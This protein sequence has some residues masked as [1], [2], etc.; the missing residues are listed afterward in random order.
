[1]NQG[2]LSGFF[3]PIAQSIFSQTGSLSGAFYPLNQNPS[4]YQNSG[5]FASHEDLDSAIVQ[6]GVTASNTFYPLTNPSGF[7]SSTY[8]SEN[9]LLKVQT[10]V[11]VSTDSTVQTITGAKT[12]LAT[13]FFNSDLYVG[14]N[15]VNSVSPDI[16]SNFIGQYAGYDATAPY[17]VIIGYNAGNAFGNIPNSSTNAIFIGQE[18]GAAVTSGYNSIFLGYQAGNQYNNTQNLYRCTP[19]NSICIGYRAGYND[20]IN[21]SGWQS[22]IIIGNYASSKGFSDS[23]AIGRGVGN[24]ATGQLNIGNILYASNI[25]A[26]NASASTPKSDGK[27]GILTG[28][29]K[30]TLEVNG[31]GNFSSGLYVKGNSVLTGVQAYQWSNSGNNIYYSGANVGINNT[32]PQY[33]LDVSGSGNFFSGLCV[34]GDII[35]NGN[36]VNSIAHPANS[37]LIGNK[38]GS[39]ATNASDSNFIGAYA[40]YS[41]VNAQYSNFF[42]Y[43]AGGLSTAAL[44]SNFFGYLAGYAA[45]GAYN[46][47]FLGLSAGYQA[48]GA[49]NNNFLGEFCGYH[50]TGVKYSTFIGYNAG[51][52]AANISYSH[53]FGWNAGNQ[54]TGASNAIF[55][56][57]LAGYL[58]VVNN[59]GNKSSILIGDYTSTNGFSNSIVI[60]K[61][62]ANSAASQLN[63]G[64]VLY[65]SN[66][67]ASAATTNVPVLNGRVGIATGSP[68]Y[69]LEVNGIGNFSSGLLVSGKSVLTGVNLTPYVTTGQTGAFYATTNP[70]GFINST[71]VVFDYG[72]QNIDGVKNFTGQIQTPNLYITSDAAHN[73]GVILFT[74]AQNDWVYNIKEVVGSGHLSFVD[75]NNNTALL[76]AQSYYGPGRVA[77]N[78]NY[79]SSYT[80]DVNGSGNF[81]SN[82]NIGGDFI[83]SGYLINSATHGANSN[84]IGYMAGVNSL[85]PANVNFFGSLA[86]SGARYASDSVFFGYQAGMSASG[87][88]DSYFFGNSAGYQSSGSTYSVFMGLNAGSRAVN[89]INSVFLGIGAGQTAVSANDC[90]YIGAGAGS[91]ANG[92]NNN[93]LGY[94]AGLSAGFNNPPVAYCNCF[95]KQ[96]GFLMLK[97]DN[98]NFIGQFA[99]YQS[100]GANSGNYLGIN[101]GYQATGAYQ[102]QFIGDSAGY[103]AT[104][105]FNSVMIGSLAGSYANNASGNSWIGG[106]AGYQAY[107]AYN[108]LFMGTQAG[109]GAYDTSFS[110]Y[111]GHGAGINAFTGTNAVFIGAYAGIGA[112]SCSN[113]NILGINAGNGSSGISNSN[114]LGPGA[115]MSCPVVESSNV[116]GNYAGYGSSSMSN[117]NYLGNSAGKDAP[118]CSYNNAFGY[119][120]GQVAISSQYNNIFGYLA[121]NNAKNTASCIFIGPNA[122]YYAS[123]ISQ[124][125]FIGSNAGQSATGAKNS[126]FIGNQAGYLDTKINNS[127]NDSSILIGNYTAT[128]GFSNSISIGQGTANSEIRQFN[129]GN[130]LY[131]TGISVGITPSSTP[132]AGGSVGIMTGAPKYTLDVNGS[133]RFGNTLYTNG[134]AKGIVRYTGAAT[135]FPTLSQSTVIMSGNVTAILPLANV[136]SGSIFTFKEIASAGF[137]YVSGSGG[138]LIDG[139]PSYTLGSQY[140]TVSMQSDGSA[141][142]ILTVF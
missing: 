107:R 117:C 12:F 19:S 98:S 25:Y 80:L 128:S 79:I 4:G 136:A 124:S 54:A 29:P 89:A 40:G 27:V 22:S 103:K 62:A 106:Q 83:V 63:I 87:A 74:E 96:A 75:E 93:F 77:I 73:P 126:I 127:T 101:A 109:F 122:G 123:G 131:G 111:I 69:T 133:G 71:D 105:A 46:S 37:N 36:L 116:L 33:A 32:N 138:N 125:T 5:S 112:T 1:M 130:V 52:S 82:L 78:Q 81:A 135:Y 14:G 7:T 31:S 41:G 85:S 84:V 99:G 72:N 95:G 30:Y 50:A 61:G 58:D 55:I 16:G 34:S 35:F 53:F 56:G 8:V 88:N 15:I 86:G 48:S 137:G 97:T 43:Y 13:G 6:Y 94:N 102:S 39:G 114:I 91:S 9:Y 70:S 21:N 134:I 28:S 18:A 3:V 24:S 115:A 38:A 17:G 139:Q 92:S 141:W 20:L 26:S 110:T 121:G 11:F 76:L 57:Y 2:E 68:N 142:W 49:Y 47:N 45:P 66:I 51:N 23:I 100:S 113:S 118:S 108:N 129:I 60:G 120:A 44:K 59:A 42:G 119:G 90:I 132:Q 10:G 67:Y 140:K 64:N 104:K 65:A